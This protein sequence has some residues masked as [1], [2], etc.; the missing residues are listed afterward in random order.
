MC[1]LHKSHCT[2]NTLIIFDQ[3]IIFSLNDN[4][5]NK[6]FFYSSKVL[7]WKHTSYW[8]RRYIELHIAGWSVYSIIVVDWWC[9][10]FCCLQHK[11]RCATRVYSTHYGRR[12]LWYFFFAAA[13]V[14]VAAV[15][16]FSNDHIHKT[17]ALQSLKMSIAIQSFR[18]ESK[19]KKIIRS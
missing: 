11:L 19:N 2:H 7:A 4:N 12:K 9:L 15:F 18:S 5:N 1:S 13:A 14:I 16:L 17:H 8:N 6:M 10:V 3:L